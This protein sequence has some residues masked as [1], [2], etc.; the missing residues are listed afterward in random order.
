MDVNDVE[1]C[2]DTLG[3]PDDPAILLIAGAAS[4]MDWWRDGFL[5]RLA[6]GGRFV[7]RY[8]TRDT[9]QSESYPPGAPGYTFDDLLADAVGVL[10]AVDVPSAQ[11]VGIS[12]GGAL[13]QLLALRHPERVDSL[14]LISTSSAAP[15]GAEL[16]AMS[17]DLQAFFGAHTPPDYTDRDAMI[18]NTVTVMRQFEGPQYFDEQ[19]VRAT[20]ARVFDRTRDM[21]ASEQNH[22]RMPAGDPPV[23]RIGDIR[24]PTLVIHGS[25]D[26]LFPLAHAEVLAGQIPG[27]KLLT[28]DGMGHQP[29]PPATWDLVVPA[30]LA[31]GHE[32]R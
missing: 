6:A 29:P 17:D 11:I 27:A 20:A 8:D 31:L 30:M 14:V 22:M 28:I 15:D 4:S 23:I 26:P 5:E 13:A 19:W 12:M 32:H 16:P 7:I 18:E 10:D 24:T 1:I 3:D 25:V 21:A 2:V 9:G